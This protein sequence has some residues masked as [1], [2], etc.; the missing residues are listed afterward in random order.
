[1]NRMLDL[2]DNSTKASWALQLSAR[3]MAFRMGM[4]GALFVTVVATAIALGASAL[5]LPGLA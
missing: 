1:M 5:P 3:W 2:I 4:L